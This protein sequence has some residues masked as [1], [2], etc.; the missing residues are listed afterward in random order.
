ME[1]DTVNTSK[2]D[3]NKDKE[4]TDSA[5]DDDSD[6]D[7]DEMT[8]TEDGDQNKVYIENFWPAKPDKPKGFTFKGKHKLMTHAVKKSKSI[9]KKKSQEKEINNTKF[10]VLDNRLVGG[11]TQVVIEIS[12]K[13]GRGNGI[14]DFWGPNKRKECTV[15]VKKSKE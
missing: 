8:D 2:I 7:I 1:Q 15:L 6:I 10:K 13:E 12:D 5:S 11:A 9:L 4:D 3:L 14:V